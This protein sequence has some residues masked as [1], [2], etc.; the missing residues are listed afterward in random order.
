MYVRNITYA[1]VPVCYY[2]SYS[3]Y[4]VMTV[5]GNKLNVKINIM[6][7]YYIHNEIIIDCKSI[8]YNIIAIPQLKY[9][10]TFAIAK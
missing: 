10:Y 7:L 3:V 4:F 5:S 8:K 1:C 9:M 6:V 2:N